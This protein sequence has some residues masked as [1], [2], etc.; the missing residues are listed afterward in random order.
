MLTSTQTWT[1]VTAT[2]ALSCL[3]SAKIMITKVDYESNPNYLTMKV[4][5]HNET[6]GSTVD[7]DGTLFLDVYQGIHVTIDLD[8]KMDGEYMTM[9][10]TSKELCSKEDNGIDPVVPLLNEEL[11]KFGN[12]TFGCPY[13]KG[14]YRMRRFRMSDDHM[15]VKMVPPGQYVVKMNLKHQQENDTKMVQ[16]YK[17]SFFFEIS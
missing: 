9:I 3:I 1:V 11:E 15:L 2:L 16:V 7:V 10:G 4:Q 6:E 14:Y 5:V 13:Y 17:L 12:L 8:S